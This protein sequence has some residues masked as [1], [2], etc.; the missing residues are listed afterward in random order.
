MNRSETE[1]EKKERKKFKTDARNLI[2]VTLLAICITLF[3]LVATIKPEIISNSPIFTLQLV[4]TI[5]FFMC[6]LL[7]RI[8]EAT[9][10]SSGRWYKLGYINFTLAY[11][12]FINSIALLL[13]FIAPT[14][15][16]FIFLAVN[17]IL[18]LTRGIIEISYKPHETKIIIFREISHLLIIIFLGILPI[19]HR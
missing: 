15:V 6:C 1:E 11:G 14:Y 13:S 9:Y 5:P 3:G 18:T 17:T 16:A 12:F 10:P 4:L 8:K 19:L 7:A 2:D